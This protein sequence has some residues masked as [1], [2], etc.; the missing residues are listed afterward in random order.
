MNQKMTFD[1]LSIILNIMDEIVNSEFNFLKNYIEEQERQFKR[2]LINFEKMIDK[3]TSGLTQE[4]LSDFWDFYGG[5]RETIEDE[6]P[7]I[8]RSSCFSICYAYLE[9]HLANIC[10]HFE[11]YYKLKMKYLKGKGIFLAQNYFN[12]VVNINFPE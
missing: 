1:N 10:K 2:N 9:K 4:E 3:Q 8:C 6:F 5:R 7:S 12:N 11:R